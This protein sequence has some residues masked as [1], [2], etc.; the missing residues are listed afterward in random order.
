MLSSYTRPLLCVRTPSMLLQL[1]IALRG[2]Q[3]LKVGGYM[4]YSTCSFNPVE[5]ECA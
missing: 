5:S 4:V 1:M 3:L 2:L